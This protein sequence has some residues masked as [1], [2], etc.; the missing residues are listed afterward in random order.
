MLTEGEDTLY[1]REI[2]RYKGED[3]RRYLDSLRIMRIRPAGGSF[4]AVLNSESLSDS[5]KYLWDV[6]LEWITGFSAKK[7]REKPKFGLSPEDLE[8]YF[9]ITLLS[10]PDFLSENFNSKGFSQ[11]NVSSEGFSD[12]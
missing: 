1:I 9:Y 12:S 2:F 7:F 4:D 10:E 6:S 5:Y 3:R 8:E 11:E